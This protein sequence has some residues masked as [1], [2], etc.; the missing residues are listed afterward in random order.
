[1]GTS[2]PRGHRIA[3]AIVAAASALAVAC[4]RDGARA[5]PTTFRV[6]TYN[7]HAGHGDLS[8]VARTVC[9]EKPD[10]VGLQ[11]VD[12]HWDAR[13]GF[14]D[15]AAE[16]AEA[17]GMEARFGPIYTLPPVDSGAPPREYGVAILTRLPVVGS[18]NHDITRLSTQ[19]ESAPAPAPGFL[20][21][22]VRLGDTEMDVYDTHLDFRPDPAVRTAQV[23]E[24]LAVIGR[25]TRPTLLLGDMNAPPERAELQ[26]LFERLHDAWPGSADPGYTFPSDAPARR[27]DYVLYGGP[28]RVDSARVP[29]VETSDHRPVVVDFTLASGP[30]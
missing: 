25:P 23:Q 9:G 18:S 8:G 26:P 11:E 16:L 27:I 6:M 15:Q 3:A 30:R 1:M 5:T 12:V 2:F 10:V 20:Q 14:A 19:A 24:M 28:L 22:T 17:C 4:A 13:S 21:V 7:I 29:P